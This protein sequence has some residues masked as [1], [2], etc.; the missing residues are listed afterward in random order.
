VSA[1]RTRKDV[2]VAES[3]WRLLEECKQRGIPVV[4]GRKQNPNAVSYVFVEQDE[5]GYAF[6]ELRHIEPRQLNREEDDT[7]ELLFHCVN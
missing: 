3:H 5:E 1:E 4:V 2:A 7:E 6:A